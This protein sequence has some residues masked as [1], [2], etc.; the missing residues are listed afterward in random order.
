MFTSHD[1][2][3]CLPVK[4]TIGRI[5]LPKWYEGDVLKD[6]NGQSVKI[7][8]ILK[9]DKY[10]FEW[11]DGYKRWQPSSAIYLNTIMREEDSSRLNPQVVEGGRYTN[12]Q[13]YDFEIIKRVKGQQ[14]L[15]RFLTDIP[16]EEVHHRSNISSG[17]VH[18]PFGPTVAG[19]GIIGLFPIDISSYQYK[20]WV[21][22]LKRV[23][24]P[25]NER[26]AI[27]Y[28][29]CSVKEDWL[30]FENFHSWSSKQIYQPGWHL[31]KDLLVPGN[32]V[33]CSDH[34]IYLPSCINV[35]L[36]DRGNE[37]GPYPRGVTVRPDTGRFQASCNN[38]GTYQY[39][40]IYDTPE[41]A[42]AVYKA[43]KERL[44]RKL[45]REWT[46]I[47]DEKAVDALMSYTVNITD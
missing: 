21:G 37:R 13:G 30:W 46:G 40:G 16:H 25:G 24:T 26:A 10:L 5:R 9:S 2:F 3:P 33:Y 44:A 34:C 15:V 45:A 35:F 6:K 29:D 36:T 11:E 18:Y 39:L 23:Y 4:I 19:H 17:T 47:I 28:G 22:M 42:F 7:S 31:D 32:R 38:A 1:S 14:F 43:E 27:N 12:F 8:K 20:S 41:E